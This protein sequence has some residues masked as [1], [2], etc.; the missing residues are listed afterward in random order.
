MSFVRVHKIWHK[1]LTGFGKF[2]GIRFLVQWIV[3]SAVVV[4][5]EMD[6]YGFKWSETDD[7]TIYQYLELNKEEYSNFYRLLEKGRLLGTLSAYNPYGENY[8]LFLPTNEAVDN[9]IQQS[10]KY[11]DFEELLEDTT[12]IKKLTRYHTL[13]RKVHSDEF[14]DGALIDKTL[15]GERLV[16]GFYTDGNTQLIK[17][18]NE[19]PVSKAN[20][21]MTNGY[22]HVISGV[23]EPLKISG[24]D[25][26]Q[27]QDE[28]S[29]LAEAMEF[30]R[31][32]NRLWF[33]KYTILAEPDSVY[34]K[35]GIYSL[36]DLLYYI[37]TPNS[38]MSKT[39][40]DFTAYHILNRDLYLN[41]LDW[42]RKGYRTM[43]S[44]YV[45]F[46]VGVKIKINPGVDI[47][48]YEISESGDT[49]VI[50]Y[51]RLIWE[52]SNINTTTGPIHT[53][54]ELLSSDPL[55]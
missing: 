8:T 30:C 32:R 31:I 34:H 41:D 48:D 18:N 45:I 35:K 38:N 43:I 52:E 19:V 55:P 6:P 33:S 1:K 29:I 13:E 50:D 37:T 16:T 5:C 44:D 51:I 20:L 14:P 42:G 12:F 3:L 39:I 54:T 21:N 7:L 46:D 15:T 11:T 40:Y 36:E 25:W 4:S 2:F 28:F 10:E 24:Y 26:L 9:F 23:L 22:I 53:I 17:V 27:Q 49:T 47:Y